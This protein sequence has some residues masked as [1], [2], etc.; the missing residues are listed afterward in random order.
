[1]QSCSTSV[2]WHTPAQWLEANRCLALTIRHRRHALAA[3]CRQALRIRQLLQAV[4]PPMDA[5]CGLTCRACAD[6]CCRR[7]W[8][9]ADFKDLL[10]FHLADIPPPPQQLLVR[11][12]DRCRYGS[13]NGCRLDRLRRPFICTWY[14]C[15][16]QRRLLR[17][18]SAI[19]DGL[20]ATLTEIQEERRRLEDRF[21]NALI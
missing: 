12:G 9:W 16:P 7:A 13:E 19:G 11:Q 21:I 4:F 3:A 1:M 15:P 10:F 14:V 2:P 20:P 6:N 18:Q 17:K 8:V 5:L